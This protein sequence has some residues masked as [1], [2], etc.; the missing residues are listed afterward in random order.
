MLK[1]G[2]LCSCRHINTV[3]FR[4]KTSSIGDTDTFIIP[5]KE[6]TTVE[7]EIVNYGS[8]GVYFSSYN[9]LGFLLSTGVQIIGPCAAFPQNAF[10]WNVKNA[11]DI[12]ED[13]LTLFFLL[14]PRLD[15]LIIGKGEASAKVNH[16]QILDICL[17][18]KINVDILPTPSAVGTF[19]FLNSEGRY[20]A[21]AVIPPSRIDLYDPADREALR[22]LAQEEE[23]ALLESRSKESPPLISSHSETV[24][25]LPQSPLAINPPS[26]TSTSVDDNLMVSFYSG[27]VP[28]ASR[29]GPTFYARVPNT[30][31]TSIFTLSGVQRFSCVASKTPRN[32]AEVV[33]SKRIWPRQG[34]DEVESITPPSSTSVAATSKAPL[35]KDLFRG[36][37]HLL[38]APLIQH[39][40]FLT[41]AFSYP[42]LVSNLKVDS[43]Q[44][45]HVGSLPSEFWPAVSKHGLC[46]LQID[47]S[48]GG[49]GLT[50]TQAAR[51]WEAV[52]LDLSVFTVLDV[53]STVSQ[54][55]M[56]TGTE[57]QK[58]RY[59]PKLTAGNHIGA[60]CLAE[61][62]SLQFA[63]GDY[64]FSFSGN[65]MNAILTEAVRGEDGQSYIING[66]KNWVT[67]GVSATLLL[68]LARVPETIKFI[69]IRAHE[70]YFVTEIVL[71]N[72]RVPVSNVLGKI[73]GGTELIRTA[74][75]RE[76][77]NLA[78]SSTGLLRYLISYATEQCLQR[79]QF[80]RPIGDYGLVR[81]MLADLALDLYA[82]ESGVF[83]FA[84]LLDAQSSRDLA[85]EL[86]GLKVFCSEALWNGMNTCMQLAG[87]TG[88]MQTI[89][90]SRYHR[91]CRAMLIYG[92]TNEL[93]RL[94]LA[95]SGLQ[96]I[97]GDVDKDYAK[98]FVFTRHPWLT[99][100]TFVRM[101]GRQRGWYAN[102]VGAGP[103]V[104]EGGSSRA[105]K[106]H[107]HPNFAEVSNDLAILVSRFQSFAEALLIHYGQAV[108]DEQMALGRAADCAVDLLLSAICMGRA[109]RAIS[110][111]LPLHDYEI[112]L[113]TTFTKL[114]CKR[115]EARLIAPIELDRERNRISSELLSHRKYPVVHPLT[116]VW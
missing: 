9:Q 41:I 92:G 107:L 12:N 17:K 98:L 103:K 51:A 31:T 23:T 47:K 45:D 113:A 52:G 76:Y 63:K 16:S 95:G 116:R 101:K 94:R 71:D 80:G 58:R 88:L 40:F 66:K 42:R 72:V 6:N 62:S 3:M 79:H 28:L 68:V 108:V 67:N 15:V 18:H 75:D 111:G 1:L 69:S 61:V 29:T 38:K 39:L 60:L 44:I 49:H 21:A 2:R 27:I 106:D 64:I 78:A 85:L 105:L 48:F 83:Y 26:P 87:R 74:L 73:G 57:D 84:G 70:Q 81:A 89:P 100:K 10:S 112:R 56:M 11:L 4:A 109:S 91:D 114:A 50:N 35:L 104:T 22:L 102:R 59:L 86:A 46:G 65:D 13:S 36:Q 7:S 8:S 19:N 34:S 77:L 93:I 54:I 97:A 43:E 25:K 99:A 5:S 55:I 14:E 30:L 96:Y 110:I 32:E 20:V 24:I 115:V 53:H 33:E 90:F 37:L 82:M